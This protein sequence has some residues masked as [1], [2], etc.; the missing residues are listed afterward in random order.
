MIDPL[1][2]KHRCFT[3]F[4][5]EDIRRVDGRL[6]KPRVALLSIFLPNLLGSLNEETQLLLLVLIDAISGLYHQRPTWTNSPLQS[7]DYRATLTQS[8]TVC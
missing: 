8:H 4:E 2:D 6:Q 5:R 3:Y 7:T 1:L